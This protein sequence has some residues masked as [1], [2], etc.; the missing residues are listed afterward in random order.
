MKRYHVVAP[1]A[2]AE[3]IEAFREHGTIPSRF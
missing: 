2:N 1:L 3:E